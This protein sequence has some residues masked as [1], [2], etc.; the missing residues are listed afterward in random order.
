MG[1]KENIIYSNV[2]VLPKAW[3]IWESEEYSAIDSKQY[4]LKAFVP[5]KGINPEDYQV[6]VS[7]DTKSKWTPYLA[8]LIETVNGGINIFASRQ[9]EDKIYIQ[10]IVCYRN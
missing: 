4:P 9:I 1:N 2:A 3:N 6:Q 5:C 8:P 10:E 7:F